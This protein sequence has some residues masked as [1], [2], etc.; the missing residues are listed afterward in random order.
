MMILFVGSA[1]VAGAV[2]V[3]ALFPAPDVKAGVQNQDYRIGVKVELVSLFATVHDAQGRIVTGLN[4]DDF[5]IYDNDIR[6]SI[7]QFS[8]E[9]MP[10]SIV[11]LLDTSGSM[12]GRKLEN[13]QKSLSRFLDRLNPGDEAMLITFD[14]RPHVAQSFTQDLEKIRRAI[15]RL[16]G[17]GS[18][19]LYDA[20]LTGLKESVNG[21]NRR[22]VLLLLSD[23]V[24]TYGR[25]ELQGTI[26]Q[27][28]HSATELF[29]IG[30]ETDVLEEMQYRNITQSV[31][32]QLTSSA[33]GESFI[34][35]RTN[36]LGR[37]CSEISERMHHQYTLAYYPPEAQTSSWRRVRIETRFPGYRIV[38]SKTGYFPAI[39]KSR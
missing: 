18:T 21:R 37:I 30:L 16:D 24:N 5:S 26:D 2:W 23:G 34:V 19:A 17:N 28:R 6:Q 39:T 35:G 38:A 32:D 25:A 10:L 7:S 4:Q 11:I 15:R 8:R 1:L 36:E 14:S 27:L 22:H 3:Q 13:A 33:G 12:A 9:Y 31:L 29:A 20:I